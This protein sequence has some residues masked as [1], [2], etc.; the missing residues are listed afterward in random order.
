MLYIFTN[1][2]YIYMCVICKCVFLKI[3]SNI[4]LNYSSAN[5]EEILGGVGLGLIIRRDRRL[6]IFSLKFLWWIFQ[7]IKYRMFTISLKS[8]FSR[9][10]LQH[11]VMSELGTSSEAR[12][13]TRGLGSYS[14]QGSEA[15]T[16]Q[17][18]RC[19]WLQVGLGKKGITE[20]AVLLAGSVAG[21]HT[22]LEMASIM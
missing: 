4:F 15:G 10:Q 19:P 6:V 18:R 16:A 8:Q 20:F 13:P 12:G 1:Y 3:W 14:W 9:W 11:L 21:S 7:F 5:L 17:Q 2:I 22:F